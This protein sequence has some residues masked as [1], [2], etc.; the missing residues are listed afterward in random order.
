MREPVKW[1]RRRWFR[2]V[3]LPLG[4]ALVIGICA[5]SWVPV[6]VR[7]VRVLGRN[8]NVW[9][10]RRLRNAS[11][12]CEAWDII[13]NWSRPEEFNRLLDS[14]GL[15]NTHGEALLFLHERHMANGASR[16]VVVSLDDNSPANPVRCG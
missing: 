16:L 6:V 14:S 5:W 9:L 3:L 11:F 13:F 12:K 4:T 15:R 1:F 7:Q 10:T 8:G 2:T